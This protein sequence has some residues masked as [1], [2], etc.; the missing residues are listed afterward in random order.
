MD[1][2]IASRWDRIGGDVVT[3]DLKLRGSQDRQRKAGVIVKV[4]SG[5]C[6]MVG[7]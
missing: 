2:I 7:G 1:Q 4:K 5:A 6:R 3:D